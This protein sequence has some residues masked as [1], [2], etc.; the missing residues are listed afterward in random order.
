[1][2]NSNSFRRPKQLWSEFD[3]LNR[4]R[5]EAA[6]DREL[7]RTDWTRAPPE[8]FGKTYSH[9]VQSKITKN[10]IESVNFA[11]AINSEQNDKWDEM[12]A[13]I[14]SSNE[15]ETW[16]V[17]RKKE[18]IFFLVVGCTKSN[19]TQT[20]VSMSSQRIIEQDVLKN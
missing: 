20:D 5:K 6:Q 11:N 15:T 14:E 16:K 10:F 18:T 2:S 17:D 8:R 9:A 3:E 4:L 13:E 7:K 1:M 19:M 12:K